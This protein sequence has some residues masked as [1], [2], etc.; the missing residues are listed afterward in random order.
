MMYK[1]RDGSPRVAS[2]IEPSVILPP[3]GVLINEAHYTPG[4]ISQSK[5]SSGRLCLVISGSAR[6][7]CGDKLCFPGVDNLCHIPARQKHVLQPFSKEPFVVYILYYRPDLLS[8]AF[9]EQL[10]ALGIVAV[11]LMSTSFEHCKV[12]R[13]IFQEILFE[14]GA[15]KQGWET[16]LHSRLLDLGVRVLRLAGR[17]GRK[18]MPTLERGNES[19]ER[20][21]QYVHCLKSQFSRQENIA[22]AARSVGLSRRQ[23]TE[24]FRKAIGQPWRQYVLNLRIKH[25][26]NLLAESDRSVSGVAFE[27][28]FDDLS[29]F[30]RYFKRF[31]GCSPL[32]YREQRRVKLPGDTASPRPHAQTPL[33]SAGFRFRGMKGWSWT[34]QQYLEEIPTLAGLRMNFLMNCYRSLTAFA[35]GDDRCNEW[36]KPL[37][38]ERKQAFAQVASACAEAGI[39]FC[40]AMHPEQASPKPLDPDVSGDVELFA[41][42]Y[43]WMQALGVRW[44]SICLDHIRW[45][46]GGPSACGEIHAAL[47]NA[48]LER[49]SSKD[50]RAQ[51]ILCPAL[52]WG[53]GTNPEHN[54]YLSSLGRNLHPDAYVF[55]S[56]DAIVTPRVT[57]VAAESYRS[58]IQHRLFLWDNYPVNDASPTL[59]L[60]PVRGRDP[61]LCDVIDG[62]LSNP[63]CAQNQINRIP[64]STCADYACN[65]KAYH[66]GRSIGQAVQRLASTVAQQQAL[67]DLIEIY[68][69]FI[70]AGGGTGTN[71]VRRAFTNLLETGSTSAARSFLNK[72]SDVLSHLGKAFP[73]CYEDARKTVRDDIQWMKA[74]LPPE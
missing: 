8:P 7:E 21:A 14:Q 68:P 26:A 25:A 60:G 45:D 71:P 39:E 59:H 48:V 63:M 62:Y 32:A 35:P 67:K 61:D 10:D 3:C 34:P 27:S 17:Q 49:L 69:G 55:W 20:V 1:L 16:M 19:I 15:A 2:S 22:E 5:E 64:L 74:K 24:L 70:V 9:H 58:I 13:S 54:A 42:H 40:F 43:E 33:Q 46:E 65:P 56:G 73:R 29:N 37:D 53:D 30:H 72:V 36:W 12:V 18:E 38:E 52:F 51:L 28:G 66:P 47:A 41:H 23:F 11:D 44:F 50:S 57:R 4:S 31:Y 6:W